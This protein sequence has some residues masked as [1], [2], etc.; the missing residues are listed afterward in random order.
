MLLNESVFAMEWDGVK[1]QVERPAM[2][3]SQAREGIE[4]AFHQLRVASR[5]DATTVLGEERTLGNHIQTGEQRQ[6]FVRAYINSGI[7][8]IVRELLRVGA[9]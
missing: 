8:A 6:P 3:E 7:R 1:V 5:L 9:A 4:P 2:L